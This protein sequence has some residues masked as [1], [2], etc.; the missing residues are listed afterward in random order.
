M[1]REF[2]AP[3][4]PGIRRVREICRKCLPAKPIR[5]LFSVTEKITALSETNHVSV[6]DMILVQ[7]LLALTRQL[8]KLPWW[9]L[10]FI[11]F[12]F[13]H[14]GRKQRSVFFPV[15]QWR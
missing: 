13:S 5:C 1:N 7:S 2:L 11:F 8:V 15:D 14:L 3:F 6:N 10:A 9:L 4:S 12:F